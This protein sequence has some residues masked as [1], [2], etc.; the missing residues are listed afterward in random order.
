MSGYVIFHVDPDDEILSFIA[1]MKSTEAGFIV[2]VVPHRAL[3]FSS[4]ITMRL[5]KRE[6]DRLG[7][8]V[9]IVTQDEQ[10]FQMA[11]RVGFFVRHTLEEMLFL[12]EE[13]PASGV[14]EEVRNQRVPQPQSEVTSVL[15]NSDRMPRSF[16]A[17]PGPYAESVKVVARQEAPIDPSAENI[18]KQPVLRAAPRSA[19]QSLFRAK[20]PRRS[21]VKTDSGSFS[22]SRERVQQTFS[23]D[24]A[25][26]TMGSHAWNDRG[27]SKGP[28]Q[29]LPKN[30]RESLS[31]K[32]RHSDESSRERRALSLETLDRQQ[33]KKAS[34]GFRIRWIV[35]GSFAIIIG[36]MFVVWMYI[37]NPEVKVTAYPKKEDISGDVSYLLAVDGGDGSV[38]AYFS[39]YQEDVNMSGSATGI[40]SG[41]GSKAYGM[42]TIYNAFSTEDQPLVAT[43]R[44]QTPDGKI[45]RITK[46]IVVPGMYEKD[47]VMQPGQVE[48]EAQADVPGAEYN[49]EATKFTIPGFSGGPKYEKI[50]AESQQIMS[51]GGA[52]NEKNRSV[53]DQ[54]II[55]AKKNIEDSI[56]TKVMEKAKTDVSSGNTLEDLIEVKFLEEKPVP[57]IGTVTDTFELQA[58]VAV[59]YI[60][61][62]DQDMENMA[63]EKLSGNLSESERKI[64]DNRSIHIEYG[65]ITTNFD[66]KTADIKMFVSGYFFPVLPVNDIR[67]DVAGKD[68]SGL[69]DVLNKYSQ[70]QSFEVEAQGIHLQN[71][72]P[73]DPNKIHVEI[74]Q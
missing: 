64:S 12:K 27:L 6:A 3:L 49:I 30:R 51:G 58:K 56:R 53:S 63:L 16:D 2:L 10:G 72:L 41:R 20:T 4:V 61:F 43:T 47:G 68:E 50:Y 9:S 71:K 60:A 13:Q 21:D 28:Y 17:V 31:E 29:D 25:D 57:S 37:G 48:V 40:A 38:Q 23:D 7:K 14:G 74:G 39:E 11:T 45:F 15:R 1:R 32:I 54:D 65:K 44:L 66:N 35:V 18:Q 8:D 59:R 62:S 26:N 5:L 70:V 36:M 34:K 19:V 33:E 67:L 52:E 73:V 46:S 42:V 24:G 22:E 69:Q 55:Q